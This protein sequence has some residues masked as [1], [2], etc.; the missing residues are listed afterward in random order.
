MIFSFFFFVID[1]FQFDNFNLCYKVNSVDSWGC[2]PSEYQGHFELLGSIFLKG[3]W[4]L[5]ML[6]R[7]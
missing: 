5:N 1:N 4:N 3:F 6:I 7:K 2:F